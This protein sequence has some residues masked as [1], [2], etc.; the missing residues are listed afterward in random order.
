MLEMPTL[1][2]LNGPGN[3][4]SLVAWTLGFTAWTLALWAIASAVF[5]SLPAAVLMQWIWSGQRRAAEEVNRLRWELAHGEHLDPALAA[6]LTQRREL[7]RRIESRQ[8]RSALAEDSAER[9]R[10]QAEVARLDSLI[11]AHSR[12]PLTPEEADSARARLIAMGRENW[13]R[14][15]ITYLF[16][17]CPFCQQFW[18][19]LA[20]LAC[21]GAAAGPLDFVATV[22]AFTAAGTA[23][24]QIMGSTTRPPATPA[25]R[26]PGCP[27]GGCG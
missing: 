5:R 9:K 3:F 26:A 13:P 2:D 8:R 14:R 27:G 24:A 1:F 7:D 23:L 25:A 18:A 12:N 10:M 22:F 11:A 4:V 15:I 21:S 6:L 16:T 20:V 19:A 17:E